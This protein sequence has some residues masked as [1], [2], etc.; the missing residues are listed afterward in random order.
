MAPRVLAI[1]TK[2]FKD[3]IRSRCLISFTVIS[4]F[5]VIGLPFVVAYALGMMAP[6]IETLISGTTQVVFPFLP[7]IALPI[8]SAAIVGERDRHTMEL[9]LAQ[10]ISRVNIFVGKF[11]GIFLAVATAIMIGMG[12]AALIVMEVPNIKFFYV[13]LIAFGLTAS[14]LGIA[15]LISTLSKDRN[16]ALGIALFFWFLFAVLIDMGFLSMIVTVAFE[17]VYM[18]PIVVANP[19]EIVRQVSTYALIMTPTM[20]ATPTR[21]GQL[22]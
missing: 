19:L 10:P 17:P 22:G 8:G 21:L 11:V 18:I 16:M 12:V 9:L 4:F 7:L 3:P 2:E 6:G 15:F 13:I 5:L 20:M 14:M 1:I